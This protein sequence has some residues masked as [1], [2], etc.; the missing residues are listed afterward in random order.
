MYLNNWLNIKCTNDYGDI[1]QYTNSA[2]VLMYMTK[3]CIEK[4]GAFDESF[5]RYGF[6][7]A[8]YSKRVA[9][10]FK[11]SP[12]LS[13][14]YSNKYIHSLDYDGPFNG[15]EATPSMSLTEV[16][17]SQRV[18]YQRW[19]TKDRPIYIPL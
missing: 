10:T 7:H 6:E 2:G 17:N 12:Y 5:G 15:I 8:D 11:M 3:E 1:G 18:A 4:V 16:M 14:K 9:D 13:P 19:Q